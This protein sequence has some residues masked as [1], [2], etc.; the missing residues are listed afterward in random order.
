[1]NKK[2]KKTAGGT[3][4]DL[5]DLYSG[6]DDPKIK[7]DKKKVRELTKKFIQ[8]YK[9]KINSPELTAELL[10]NCLNDYEKILEKNILLSN[11]FY[12]RYSKNTQ[13]EKAGHFFQKSKA[14]STEISGRLIWFDLEWLNV[15]NDLAEKLIKSPKLSDYSH[16]LSYKQKFKPFRLSEEEELILTKKSQ[17]SEQAFVQLYDLVDNGLK[18]KLEVDSETKELSQSEL[19]P[20]LT[21]HPNRKVRK[22]AAEAFTK[23]ISTKKKL[24]AYILN[25]LLFDKKI[26]DEIRGYNYPQQSTFLNYEVEKQI[27]NDLA[28]AVKKEYSICE[29]FYRA[30]R[31]M[32][33]IK[34]LHEWDR[35]SPIYQT[36]KN[37]SWTEAKEIIINSFSQFSEKFSETAKLFFDNKWID[38]E[39][40]PG[41]R[42]GA[43]CSYGTPSSHPYITVNFTG[44]INDILTL[45]HELGHGIHHYLS[46]EQKLLEFSASTA[47]SEIASIFGESL[48]FDKLIKETK[49]KKAKTNLLANQLQNDF[50]S[51]F[52]QI[53]FYEF[54]TKIHKH[55]R[56]KGELS[57]N[58][59]GKYYQQELQK[60][61]GQGLQLTKNH[62]YWWIPILHFY[63]YNF[64]VFTYSMGNLIA[65]SL[66]NT[67]RNE[68]A[69]FVS[70]YLT[71]LKNGGSKTPAEIMKI[72][73]INIKEKDF[74]Q[75]GLNYIKDLVAKFEK[76]NNE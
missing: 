51:I 30:K 47:V 9:G 35:Y 73:G 41:K 75:K 17:T 57:V 5:S 12:Y 19:K 54:E 38:A 65:Y 34:K 8:K 56:Q 7:K 10:K 74:W 36:D 59:F 53:A 60:T 44:E 69:N 66:Y 37:Y 52:R 48:V 72:M 2:T 3:T 46:R 45:A 4:W 40:S 18:F 61:F 32:L 49:N 76:L 63:H 28:S 50:A 42:S 21:V 64:Y 23:G 29:R 13:S 43:Y 25:T 24:F 11:Y 31:K 22:S 20:Y 27:V 58:D 55:R 39:L 1:M 71:A 14:F 26:N 67:Y 62:R 68:Q 16:Y 33:K 6:F 15:D 70:K